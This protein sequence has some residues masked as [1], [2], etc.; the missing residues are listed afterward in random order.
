[1]YA[2]VPWYVF[3]GMFMVVVEANIVAYNLILMSSSTF[4]AVCIQANKCMAPHRDTLM[5][6]SEMSLGLG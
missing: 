5:H 6:G 2:M 1:M 3:T 4:R